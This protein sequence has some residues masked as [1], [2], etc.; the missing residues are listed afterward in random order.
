MKFN[1][2]SLSGA[3]LL[4][5]LL[6]A[7]ADASG[8]LP[9][10][11]AALPPW[12]GSV[13]MSQNSGSNV[14]FAEVEFAVYAPGQFNASVTLGHPAD[15][16]A[17]QDYVYAYEIFND[18][19]NGSNVTINTLSVGVDYLNFPNAIPVPGSFVGHTS[20]PDGPGVAPN[21]SR[22]V[23]STGQPKHSVAWNYT[24]TVFNPGQHSDILF[25]ASP[26]APHLFL[27]SLGGGQATGASNNLPSPIPEPATAVLAVIAIICLMSAKCVR[28][29]TI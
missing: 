19:A 9:T 20:G 25:F 26:W 3:P 27:S 18:A 16:S 5:L 11:A 24:T 8:P 23:P 13:T 10:D 4:V 21:L 2:A 28:R 6:S 22:F 15:P 29:R 17:G 7:T 14:L 1:F 12:Q